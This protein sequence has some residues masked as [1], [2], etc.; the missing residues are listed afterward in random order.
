MPTP[1]PKV[2]S[3]EIQRI[4]D[5]D[6]GDL[7]AYKICLDYEEELAAFEDK[8]RNVRILGFLLLH[9]PNQG[10][11]SEVTK[12]IHSLKHSSDLTD[13][14]AF[15]ERSVILPFKKYRGRT[16]KPSERPSRP[17]FEVV[18]DQ[19]KVDITLAPENHEDA[20]D[21]ALVRDNWRCVVTGILDCRAP[22]RIIAQLDPTTVGVYTQCTHII[23]EDMCF[24]VEP[25]SKENIK[26][27]YSASVLAVLKRFGCDIN[28]FN[29]E[30][31]HSLTN[32]I[33]VESN[34]HEAFDRL[35]LY[36]EA[37]SHEDRY[38]VKWF[39]LKPHPNVRQFVEF[40]TSD[41]ENL[42]V[43]AYELLALHATC[44]K[45]AHFSG[46]AEYI[47]EIYRDA[48]KLDVLSADGTSGDILDYVLLSL[49][50]PRGSNP[51][52]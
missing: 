39:G 24:G 18:K 22:E 48:D 36:F 17:S 32:V 49:L 19:V 10:V 29:G 3:P 47:D 31:V 15:F 25:K 52:L 41:P 2:D 35:M 21:R 11:R 16:P 37:T 7:S 1:L 45:V 28:R 20:K 13:V 26:L 5:E 46:A 23:P 38:E 33:S 9:V 8:L 6:S 34:V 43:P 14:G 51:R 42:P 40:S 27:D 12:C 50:K 44:C 4:A 30:N